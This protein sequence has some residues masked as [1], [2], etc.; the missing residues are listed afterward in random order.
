[1]LPEAAPLTGGSWAMFL[2]VDGTLLDIADAPDLVHVDKGLLRLLDSL[3]RANEGAV[4]LVSGRSIADLDKL[5]SPLILPAAGLHGAERRDARRNVHRQPVDPRLRQ[6]ERELARWSLSRPGT[7]VEDKGGAVALHYRLAPG[8]EVAARKLI[9]T[10]ASSLGDD[11]VVQSGKR[12]VEIKPSG[13]SKATAIGEF[14]REAPFAGR[15]PVFV[16][17]DAT[18]EDGFLA[19]RDLGGLAVGVGER[20][21]HHASCRLADVRAVEDWLIDWLDTDQDGEVA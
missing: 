5:F 16:G 14:M 21:F 11:Y 7:L 6:V 8:E 3:V 15:R 20:E 13:V 9:R 10:V 19:V 17:D 2:D 18:D 1:M 4:A 12:V